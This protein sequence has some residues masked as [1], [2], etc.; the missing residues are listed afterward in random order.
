VYPLIEGLDDH[1]PF[2]VVIADPNAPVPLT[3]GCTVFDGTAYVSTVTALLVA[4]AVPA[5]FVPVTTQVIDAELSAGYA[6]VNELVVAP[7]MFVPLRNH[8]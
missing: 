4:L 2:V 3:V 7:D 1:V 5:E 8:W 6:G